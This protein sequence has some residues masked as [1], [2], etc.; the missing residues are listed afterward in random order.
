MSRL[1]IKTPRS[2]KLASHIYDL[3][4]GKL[5][6]D[7]YDEFLLDMS[8][9][10]YGEPFAML[11]LANQFKEMVDKSKNTVFLL[12]YP[13]NNFGGYAQHI[14]LFNYMGFALGNTPDSATG[15]KNYTP[16]RSFSISKI[17][18]DRGDEPVG[19]YL[20][21][22][23]SELSQV[24][25]QASEGAAFDLFE[26][27][28]REIMRN[29]AEHSEG[30]S[31]VVMGQHWPSQ[32][33]AEIVVCDN[34]IGIANTLYDNEYIDCSTNREAL[35][36]ALLPGVSGVSREERFEQDEFWGNSG[37][38]LYV[39][40]RFCSEHGSFRMISGDSGL[41]LARGYQTE[42]PAWG[43]GGTCV[44]MRFSTR[45]AENQTGRIAEIIE[46]GKSDF[47]GILSDYPI[48]PSAASKMLASHFDKR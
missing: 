34:G 32:H 8:E 30:S 15:S 42:H 18:A 10:S 47:K 48:K 11:L 24:L 3:N 38:G 43:F 31:L 35:K 40:S 41:T 46:E 44:Q 13:K 5:L 7:K 4:L 23:S 25:C 2:L 39:T 29:S 1:T 22:Y 21:S 37:F 27:C 12:K 9:T 28:L 17:L 6:L 26:Y 19:K 16:I 14:G 20:T 36:F 33:T 45:Q